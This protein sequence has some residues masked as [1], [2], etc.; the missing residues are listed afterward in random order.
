MSEPFPL[1]EDLSDPGME[2]KSPASQ[3]D[4]LPSETPGKLIIQEELCQLLIFYVLPVFLQPLIHA[5]SHLVANAGRRLRK[6]PR[7]SLVAQW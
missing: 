5:L 1:P 2:L 4:S 7:A 6:L 3:A